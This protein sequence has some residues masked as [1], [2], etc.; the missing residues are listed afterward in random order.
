MKHFV[1]T[2]GEL[3][4]GLTKRKHLIGLKSQGLRDKLN[5]ISSSRLS[6]ELRIVHQ[7]STTVE[8]EDTTLD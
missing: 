5:Y 6:V 8:A 2:F 7:D 4:T 1:L 3:W